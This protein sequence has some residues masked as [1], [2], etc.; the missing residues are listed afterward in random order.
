MTDLNLIVAFVALGAFIGFIAGWW[1]RDLE[2]D[3]EN[4]GEPTEHGSAPL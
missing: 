1:I 2:I 4:D 3:Y